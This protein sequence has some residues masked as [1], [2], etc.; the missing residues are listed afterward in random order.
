MLV[1]GIYCLSPQTKEGNTKYQRILIKG[2]ILHSNSYIKC[3]KKENSV[4]CKD[5]SFYVSD[6][7]KVENG[8]VFSFCKRLEK[9]DQGWEPSEKVLILE[10]TPEVSSIQAVKSLYFYHLFDNLI[11]GN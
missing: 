9:K 8:K 3:K 4:F 7:F 10:I 5:N 6:S 11:I 2:K 1:N